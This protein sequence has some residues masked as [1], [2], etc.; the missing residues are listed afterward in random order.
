MKN[1]KIHLILVGLIAV[2]STQAWAC[3]KCDGIKYR[4]FGKF[5]IEFADPS[6]TMDPTLLVY[7]SGNQS[8]QADWPG[9]YNGPI[10]EAEEEAVVYPDE[11]FLVSGGTNDAVDI[12][13]AYS[14]IEVRM[15]FPACYRKFM[16]GGD[17]YGI[18]KGLKAE[19]TNSESR[20]P[21]NIR[22]IEKTEADEKSVVVIISC[23]AQTPDDQLAGFSLLME[24][25]TAGAD[26]GPGLGSFKSN[27][28][29]GDKG[30]VKWY[31]AHIEDCVDLESVTFS[32]Y[33]GDPDVEEVEDGSRKQ[34]RITNQGLV[35]AGATAGQLTIRFYDE[36]QVGSVGPGGFY[37]TSGTPTKSVVVEEETGGTVSYKEYRSGVISGDWT[38]SEGSSPESFAMVDN[39]T[40]RKDV[41][42]KGTE[43]NGD[44]YQ[45]NQVWQV[46][47]GQPE[48]LVSSVK[49]VYRTYEIDADSDPNTPDDVFEKLIA[50]IDDPDGAA[51]TTTYTY[52]ITP[53]EEAYQRKVSTLYPDGSWQMR[54]YGDLPSGV[55]GITWSGLNNTAL[56]P[57]IPTSGAGYRKRVTYSDGTDEVYQSDHLTERDKETA[58]TGTFAGVSDLE[59]TTRERWYGTGVN[60]KLTSV[61]YEYPGLESLGH[62][63][64]RTLATVNADQ[65]GSKYAY[66]KGTYNAGTGAFTVDA[67][68]EDLKTTIF[69]GKLSSGGGDIEFAA[70]KS[71]ASES[72]TNA[73][74]ETV[75]ES[76]LVYNG[77][78]FDMMASTRHTYT[79]GNLVES[80][81]DGEIIYSAVY[82]SED[83]LESSTDEFGVVTTMSESGNTSTYTMDD[84]E[85]V[86]V[87]TTVTD[88][89]G[90]IA[91]QTS[92][93]LVTAYAYEALPG[94]GSKQTMTLPSTATSITETYA[95]GQLKAIYGTAEVSRSFTYTPQAGGMVTTESLTGGGVNRMIVS[96]RD[97]LGRTT[98][99]TR[100]KF[101]GGT[102][103]TT[104]AYNTKGQ[105]ESVTTD[106]GVLQAPMGYTYDDRGQTDLSGLDLDGAGLSLSSTEDR[107]AKGESHYAQQGGHWYQVSKQSRN[108]PAPDGLTVMSEVWSRVDGRETIVKGFNDHTMTT[109]I[110]VDRG[111]QLMTVI[112][113]DS[114]VP[115]ARTS[116]YAGGATLKSVQE[117]WQAGA[118]KTTYAYDGNGRLDTITD[119]L[120]RETEYDYHP[121]GQ[122]GAGRVSVVTQPDDE[123][124]S[125]TYTSR[126]ELDVESGSA[127]Y[128]KDFDYNGFGELT[129]LKTSGAAGLATTEWR[130]DGGTGL[131]ERKIDA[132]NKAVIY[133]YNAVGWVTSRE[134]ARGVTT[135]YGYTR[136]GEVDDIDYSDSTPDVTG[137]SYDRAGRLRTVTDAAGARTMTY[138]VDGQRANETFGGSGVLA[139]YGIS[140]EFNGALRSRMLVTQPG[141][142]ILYPEVGYDYDPTTKAMATI[143]QADVTVSYTPEPGL[144]TP[145]TTSVSLSGGVTLTREVGT[146]ALGRTTSVEAT[147]GSAVVASFGTPASPIQYDAGGRR[148][149][150]PRKDGAKWTYGYNAR[151]EVTSG[152]KSFA[153]GSEPIPGHQFG[154][155]YDG[156][157]NRESTEVGGDQSGAD[158]ESVD[159]TPNLLNQY[160]AYSSPTKQWITGEAVETAQVFVNGQWAW[161]NG[162]FFAREV[163]LDNA[164][165]PSWK[166]LTV[167]S[168]LLPTSGN[169]DMVV[170]TESGN[171]LT[172]PASVSTIYDDDGNLMSDGLWSYT[173]NGENRLIALQS[174]SSVP[175]AAQRR[176]EYVYDFGG[177][178]IQTTRYTKSGANWVAAGT[179]TFLF[180]GWNLVAERSPQGDRT[181]L[182]GLDLSGTLERAG[183]IGGLLALS[184][185]SAGTTHSF[186]YDANGNVTALFNALTGQTNATY[187]YGP[188][189]EPLRASGP[190]AMVN[191]F[192]RSSKYT[193][194][195]S[196]FVYYG[197]RY[198]NPETGRWLNRD[199]IGERGGV[200]LYGFVGNNPINLWDILGLKWKKIG[201]NDDES[202]MLYL[203]QSPSDT[204]ED[205]AS[206]VGLNASEHKNWAIPV[207]EAAD[208][209]DSEAGCK[210]SVPNIWIST[211]FL[212]GPTLWEK[213]VNLGAIIGRPVSNLGPRLSGKKVIS[214]TS[215]SGL[216]G[217][218]SK[219]RT[220]IWGMVVYG[221]GGRNGYLGNYQGTDNTFQQAVTGALGGDYKIAVARL[222]Q[223]YGLY[224]GW[225]GKTYQDFDSQWSEVAIDYKGYIHTNILG[226]DIPS[227][228]DPAPPDIF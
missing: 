41:K 200:N 209:E 74:D 63:A 18:G 78:G 71:T 38:F 181:Y 151:G 150:I 127:T 155:V 113:S 188:F 176:F 195:E 158:L 172:P 91:S 129:H 35:D 1:H 153:G 46:E 42:I 136:A 125:Y 98:S 68:G 222:M 134:W 109:S 198:Y 53:G 89:D 145:Q 55:T 221:H 86:S 93:G 28:A 48:E 140:R 13:V 123:T 197:Y 184:D 219:H 56:P 193:E 4:M 132:A 105:L 100:P 216:P 45:T 22:V 6:D 208:S 76:E 8:L 170:A 160:S 90:R 101:G 196:G 126:G 10:I 102:S 24:V 40:G 206:I 27:F 116:V 73:D 169:P 213:F 50:S 131:V 185:V 137:M 214:T 67:N 210:Y 174:V 157:G 122:P 70:N 20:L 81:R 120:N 25:I 62:L 82:D 191:P 164:S 173:W 97:M 203:R 124:I 72:V 117:P 128:W 36:S 104:H 57:S 47:S 15:Q 33:G 11:Q 61:S 114:R 31:A 112:E 30:R 65:T 220:D 179:T 99:T 227:S 69:R 51:A 80:V 60:D 92:Q 183:G 215:A 29:L 75:L 5:D 201:P 144:P 161:R 94:G 43:V 205:L 226:F 37:A 228:S 194:N 84:G 79:D 138:S 175:E 143:T 118:E 58:S 204:F 85:V 149:V 111:N 167:E 32:Y 178:R 64:Q 182:W 146:D 44:R 154:Y 190:M 66:E 166:D 16:I 96:V 119:A 163:E 12:P 103:E 34:T 165:A 3:S 139:G 212:N 135:T 186:T 54:Q 7:T 9:D 52:G 106:G 189:G 107:I 14:R 88:V 207:A 147:V 49:D 77:S 156:I 168:K 95:D 180:D 187:E 17:E 199:P 217:L 224:K 23:E 2:F 59:I 211:N 223:C 115:G 171:L 110:T 202:R 152:V 192:R 83:N 142:A 225:D 148:Q 218:I 108:L 87:S 21:V 39:S 177:R 130:R 19:G 162:K 133:Q 159:Y 141:G 26:E 121:D